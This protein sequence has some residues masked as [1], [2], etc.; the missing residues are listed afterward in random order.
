MYLALKA[1]NTSLLNRA[2]CGQA[3]EAYSIIVTG[4]LGLPRVMSSADAWLAGFW[5][6]ARPSMARAAARAMKARISQGSG[7]RAENRT[8]FRAR[9]KLILPSQNQPSWPG[10][11]PGPPMRAAARDYPR[12][13][14]QWF[15]GTAAGGDRSG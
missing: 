8:R 13:R 1:G 3:S 7:R 2:Q 12:V 5:Q 15:D 11:S 14:G 6:A 4:A 9:L 10:A